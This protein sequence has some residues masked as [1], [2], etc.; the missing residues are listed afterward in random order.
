LFLFQ[1][2][3]H[4]ADIL[5]D[6]IVAFCHSPLHHLYRE[7]SAAIFL[8]HEEFND[9]IIRRLCRSAVLVDE[10]EGGSQGPRALARGPVAATRELCTW[11]R[12]DLL[13]GADGLEALVIDGTDGESIRSAS[14]GLSSELATS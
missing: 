13:L 8:V 1:E 5:C 12:I 4:D 2:L 11:E 14:S 9:Q 6:R 7:L 3:A 10:V